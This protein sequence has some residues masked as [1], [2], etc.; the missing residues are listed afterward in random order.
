MTTKAFDGPR[1]RVYVSAGE[2]VITMSFGDFVGKQTLP[3]EWIYV[4]GKSELEEIKREGDTLLLRTKDGQQVRVTLFDSR[5]AFEEIE[6]WIK[7]R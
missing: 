3:N 1:E 7:N 6:A 5:E 2:L 4:L